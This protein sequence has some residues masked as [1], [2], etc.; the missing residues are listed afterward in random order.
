[1]RRRRKNS[2]PTLALVAVVVLIAYAYRYG[3]LTG[4]PAVSEDGISVYFSP[5]GGCTSAVV[6]QIDAARRSIDVEA[7]TFTSRP[8]AQALIEAHE[9]GVAVRVILDDKESRESYSLGRELAEAGL[10][11]F[12]DAHYAI[13]HNK[14]MIMDDA[15]VVTGSFN[16]TMQAENSNAENLLVIT[17]KPKL[18][19]AYEENFSHHLNLSQSYNPPR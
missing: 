2:V 5:G 13:A 6:N 11:V 15:T 10:A 9:R 4:A 3:Q 16:F 17:G 8:I 12:T 19:Q 1:M 18:A 7:Y 14:I